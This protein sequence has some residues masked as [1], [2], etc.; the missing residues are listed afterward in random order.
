MTRHDWL[1][2][3]FTRRS[4]IYFKHKT[5]LNVLSAHFGLLVL[6]FGVIGQSLGLKCKTVYFSISGSVLTAT[7]GLP[8]LFFHRKRLLSPPPSDNGLITHNLYTAYTLNILTLHDLF[9]LLKKELL[10][11]PQYLTESV[12][13]IMYTIQARCHPIYTW[14]FSRLFKIRVQL[15]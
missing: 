10:I 6:I 13:G 2:P 7:Q 11:P 15:L 12:T 3:T 8:R 1:R 14:L 5:H 4:E 9:Q